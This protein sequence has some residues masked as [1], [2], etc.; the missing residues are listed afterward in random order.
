MITGG[1]RDGMMIMKLFWRPSCVE[2]EE[3][4]RDMSSPNGG[5]HERGTN[6]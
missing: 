2:C 5:V 4:K 6:T 3:M 1:L